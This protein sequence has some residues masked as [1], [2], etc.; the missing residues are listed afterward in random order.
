MDA[1]LNQLWQ[2]KKRIL[3]NLSPRPSFWLGA[4]MVT[5]FIAFY[6]DSQPTTHTLLKTESPL[7]VTTLIPPGFVL[8]P[9]EVSNFESLDSILGQ[10]GVVD[11]YAPGEDLKQRPVKIAEKIKILRA[12]LNP[13]HFAVL[14]PEDE[15]HKLVT[16]LGPLMVVVQPQAS[17][18]TKIVN[19]PGK[20]ALDK[21][22]K[23]SKP[24]SRT[25]RIEIE[26][27]EMAAAESSQERRTEPD[28]T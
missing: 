25:S 14:A 17:L 2:I 11:L 4:V 26:N 12:P 1:N 23:S 16:Q 6:L 27:P 21:T 7:D 22:F 24:R 3:Q 8:V 13:S 10:H 18:G 9:I 19:E 20:A 15:S 28:E 5:G